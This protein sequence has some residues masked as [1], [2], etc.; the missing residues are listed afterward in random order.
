VRTTARPSSNETGRRL[1]R[2]I[3]GILVRQPWTGIIDSSAM[4]IRS[5]QGTPDEKLGLRSKSGDVEDRT[6]VKA[7]D[8]KSTWPERTFPNF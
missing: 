4:P 3:V 6:R 2:R 5:R 1:K 7:S 8:V